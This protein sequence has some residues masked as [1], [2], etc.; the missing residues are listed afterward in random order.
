MKKI[1]VI[2]NFAQHYRKGIF[3]KMDQ[4]F[5][6]DFYFG[7]SNEDIK[8]LDYKLLKNCEKLKNF[9]I[10]R[11]IYWQSGVTKLFFREYTH[12]IFLG[13]YYCVST[14]VILI[15]GLFSKK[16]V[17][18]WTHGWYGNEGLLKIVFK[19]IFFKMSDGLLL[20][21]DYAK[22]LMIKHGF[23]ESNLH[24]IYNSLDFD[25]QLEI[26]N[27]LSE[28]LVFKN[29]FKNNDPTLIFVGRLT[30][31]KKLN[32]IILLLE[33]LKIENINVNFVFLGDGEEKSK[34]QELANLKKIDKI[35]FFGSCYNEKKIAELI[36]NSNLCISPGN[37]G[38]TAIHSL[39]YGTPV[40]TNDSFK[41][42]MPE[43]EVIDEGV[44]GGFF[45]NDDL[46]SLLR[47]TK[48]WLNIKKDRSVIR[49][50]CFL[51]I[52]SKYNPYY[53]LEIMKK[54]INES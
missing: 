3:I 38:L 27:Q 20:Y 21:G 54:I 18:L 9:K 31:V 29:Y 41:D 11:Q 46:D 17:F 1:A 5:N 32:L 23:K 2:Y 16:K 6:V 19:K 35:W 7:N 15:L 53:Q 47:L 26:R 33:R 30:K 28:S 4:A 36:F 8:S 49:E 24:V 43:F 39:T 42:Q 37:V 50:S 13:E 25:F 14:W 44:T 48:E 10:F 51:K 40:L 34:L 22:D 45:K 52:D 12:Y